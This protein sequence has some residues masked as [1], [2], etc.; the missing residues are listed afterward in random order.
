MIFEPSIKKGCVMKGSEITAQ[1]YAY[2]TRLFAQDEQDL[3]EAMKERA[4]E[5]GLPEIMISGEQAKLL[6]VLI[7]IHNPDRCLDIGTLFGFSAT[8]MA[9]SMGEVGEVVTVERQPEHLDVAEANFREQGVDDRITTVLGDA[10]EQ[11]DQFDERSFDLVMIDADKESYTTY[12]RKA[13]ELVRGGGLILAD[14]T[15]YRGKVS[16][17]ELADDDPAAPNARA[18][19]AYNKLAAEHPD[20]DSTIIPTGDGFTISR[21]SG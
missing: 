20:T 17:D 15:L 14:N 16:V 10:T 4:D 1:D 7:K 6:S 19:R 21:Y 18:I 2:I 12:F 8:I 5:Q 11:I 13:I 9:R 3:M